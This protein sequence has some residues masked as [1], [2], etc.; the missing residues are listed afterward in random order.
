MFKFLKLNIKYHRLVTKLISSI[1]FIVVFF[2]VLFA[3]ECMYPSKVLNNTMYY[4]KTYLL[5]GIK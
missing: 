4:I 5:M 1:V 3:A 2:C